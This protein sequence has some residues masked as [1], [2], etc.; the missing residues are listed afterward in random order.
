MALQ[1]AKLQAQPSNVY[2]APDLSCVLQHSWLWSSS[3]IRLQRRVVQSQNEGR[4][5]AG[6]SA[7][8]EME[9]YKS[10]RRICVERTTIKRYMTKIW[11]RNDQNVLYLLIQ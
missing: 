3:R 7:Q 11:T 10:V 1:W 4:K 2:L 8:H 9:Y 5:E 6:N